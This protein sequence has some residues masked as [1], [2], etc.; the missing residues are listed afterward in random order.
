VPTE[1]STVDET[2]ADVVYELAVQGF[3]ELGASDPK[4]ISRS[5]LLRN[6]CYTGQRYRCEG[7]QAVWL[8]D[9]ETVEF[10]DA[11]GNPV[12]TL[13]LVTEVARKAA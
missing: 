3:T 11:A 12:K 4:C 10:H 2:Q 9:G 13:T 6:M 8:L 7:W 5:F 1:I